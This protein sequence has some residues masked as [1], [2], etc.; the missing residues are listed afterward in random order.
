MKFLI[1]HFDAL[2]TIV[3]CGL[4]LVFSGK[5]FV[6]RPERRPLIRIAASLAILCSLILLLN[7]PVTRH[8]VQSSDDGIAE[9]TFPGK[10]T[11]RLVSVAPG[12]ERVTYEYTPTDPDE[13]FSLSQLPVTGPFVTMSDV[14]RIDQ[15]VAGLASQG[16]VVSNRSTL[17]KN[18]V[19]IHAFQFVRAEARVFMRI[20]YVGR[21][22]YRVT[23]TVVGE[24]RTPAE[25]GAFLESFALHS[26][27]AATSSGRG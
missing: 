16:S 18:G 27:P 8:F 1:T 2:S 12:I 5:M 14:E 9:A 24:S 20:A 21:Q 6:N 19:T 23:A 4:I 25:I 26:I 13:A 10:P 11:K 7:R 15:I 3:L 22:S 17:A